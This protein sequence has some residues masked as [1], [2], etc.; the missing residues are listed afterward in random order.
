MVDSDAGLVGGVDGVSGKSPPGKKEE[1]SNWVMAVTG[2]GPRI[3]SEGVF[4]MDIVR[5]SV[6]E[7]PAKRASWLW[8]WIFPSGCQA[9]GAAPQIEKPATC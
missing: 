2:A 3:S 6:E 9:R 5:R 1:S 8:R 4:G 7:T